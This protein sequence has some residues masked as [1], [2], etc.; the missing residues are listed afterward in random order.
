[1]YEPRVRR[2]NVPQDRGR[3]EVLDPSSSR[4]LFLACLSGHGFSSSIFVIDNNEFRR[5][6]MIC[7]AIKRQTLDVVEDDYRT[8]MNFLSFF[9][10]SFLFLNS[11]ALWIFLI[12]FAVLLTVLY[13][14]F[15]FRFLIFIWK[16][17]IQ[18]ICSSS[19][20]ILK[21]RKINVNFLN[22]S[23]PCYL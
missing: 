11:G 2:A 9:F 15:F 4:G 21:S 18:F 12:T 16:K 14:I 5:P 1:M 3:L 7:V 17:L 20:D 8:H 13:I 22:K 19:Y 10:L 6:Q 23:C